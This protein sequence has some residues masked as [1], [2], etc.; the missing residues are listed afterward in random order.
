[1]GEPSSYRSCIKIDYKVN[2]ICSNEADQNISFKV[3]REVIINDISQGLTDIVFQDSNLGT[4]MGVTSSG[5]YCGSFID[6]IYTS[7]ASTAWTSS[8]LEAQDIND[9]YVA[10]RYFL[11]NVY[12]SNSFS[13]HQSIKT[14]NKLFE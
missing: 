9:I 1:M 5:I 7:D 8:S 6:N 14:V 10:P 13:H 3:T 11:H 12:G 4:A 2:Y